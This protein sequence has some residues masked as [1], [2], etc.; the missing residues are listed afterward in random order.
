[1]L[2]TCKTFN[3]EEQRTQRSW[4]SK[5]EDKLKEARAK[6]KVQKI[7]TETRSHREEFDRK[8]RSKPGASTKEEVEEVRRTR[9]KGK[10]QNQLL[11]KCRRNTKE[12]QRQEAT[13][14]RDQRTDNRNSLGSRA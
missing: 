3:T 8:P 1:D 13:G 12:R 2:N 4:K 7:T 11:R 9:S 14:H 5:A 6:A 10:K